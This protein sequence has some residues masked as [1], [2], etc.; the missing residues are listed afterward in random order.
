MPLNTVP[1][2]ERETPLTAI[3]KAHHGEAGPSPNGGRVPAPTVFGTKSEG[4]TPLTPGW[5]TLSSTGTR[6]GMPPASGSFT[7]GVKV[8]DS[9]GCSGVQVTAYGSVI[10]QV[11]GDPTYV[12][13]Q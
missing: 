5:L 6:A 11:T 2:Q 1:R 7:F 12:P 9:A 4:V 13:A 3:R 8:L 10:D